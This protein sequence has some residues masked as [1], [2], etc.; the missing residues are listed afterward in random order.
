MIGYAITKDAL[1]KLIEGEVPGWLMKAAERT[2][3]FKKD[4]YYSARQSQVL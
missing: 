3:Q 4:G 2:A 1:E